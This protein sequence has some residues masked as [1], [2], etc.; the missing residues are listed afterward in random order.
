MSNIL[1]S[2]RKSLGDG[3]L[4]YKL[5]LAT[6]GQPLLYPHPEGRRLAEFEQLANALI[7]MQGA[8]TSKV[9][10][11]SAVSSGEGCSYVSYNVARILGLLL[12]TKVAWVD[13]NFRNPQRKLNDEGLNFRSLLADPSHFNEIPAGGD[14][15]ALPHGSLPVKSTSLLLSDRYTELLSRFQET[16][17]FTVLDAPAILD[18]VDV[19]HIAAPTMGLVLVV[20]SRRQ[21]REV[22]RHSIETMR[23]ANVNV[24][25]TVLNRRVFDI[26][27]FLYK[28]L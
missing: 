24:L 13:A 10:T 4:A 27:K 3:E 26:P 12:D 1:T 20:E 15:Y 8:G 25:G 19:G 6:L 23:Q 7:G 22:I 14:F 17:L 11:F 21:E 18:T 2:V 28:R 5:R 9:V 16:F